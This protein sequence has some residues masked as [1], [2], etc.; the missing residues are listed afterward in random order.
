MG[1]D[2]NLVAAGGNDRAMKRD[3]RFEI[4]EMGLTVGGAAHIL[5]QSC[6][7]SKAFG[8]GDRAGEPAREPFQHADHS[9]HVVQL[10]LARIGNEVAPGARQRNQAFQS[11]GANRLPD[12]RAGGAQKRRQLALSHLLPRGQGALHDHAPQFAGRLI[13]QEIAFDFVGCLEV[14]VFHRL[15]FSLA[16]TYVMPAAIYSQNLS[17]KVDHLQFW[18]TIGQNSN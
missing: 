3:V 2:Q 14:Q 18:Y 9:E 10:V 8:G 4:I 12:R 7:G 1:F 17:E 15:S 5:L 16:R 13:R 6:N 11:Q